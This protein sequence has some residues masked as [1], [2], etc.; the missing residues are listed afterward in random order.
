MRIPAWSLGVLALGIAAGIALW[1][2]ASFGGDAFFHL[3][4][5]RKL[6]DF[7]SISL[8]SL[9]EYKD[10]GLHPG[11]AFPLWHGA[12]AVISKLAG[13]DP[14]EVVLHGPT[15]LLPLFFVLT[16]ESGLALF[17]SRWAGLMTML[18]T[19]ALLGLAPGH[20]GSL[21]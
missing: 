7:G 17:R 11:Y 10:G 21:V 12:L 6:V 14:S 5:V 3:A 1:W 19:F 13:V 9:D 18:V 20:G 15:V 8:K 2:V 16:Y 4:R